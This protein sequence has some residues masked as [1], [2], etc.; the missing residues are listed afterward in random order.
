[1]ILDKGAKNSSE[2]KGS[3]TVGLSTHKR[4][5]PDHSFS[6]CAKINSK[7]IKYLNMRPETLKQ[8]M[9][10]IGETLQEIGKGKDF[11]N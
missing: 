3:S 9:E 10:N 7:W 5:K 1:L 6:S 11:L 2:I 4:L 8:L